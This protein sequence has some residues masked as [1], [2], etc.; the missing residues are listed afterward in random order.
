MGTGGRLSTAVAVIETVGSGASVAIEGTSASVS[1][2][3]GFG[4]TC[5][6]AACLSSFDVRLAYSR[7]ASLLLSVVSASIAAPPDASVG[8]SSHRR[9]LVDAPEVWRLA[10]C[11]ACLHVGDVCAALPC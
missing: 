3:P 1:V 11:A 6:P 2:P 10:C 4:V 9:L 7:N 8:A 5:T